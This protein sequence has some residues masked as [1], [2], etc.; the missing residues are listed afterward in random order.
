MATFVCHA[1]ASARP[2]ASGA[3]YVS[4]LRGLGT[5]SKEALANSETR[6]PVRPQRSAKG[7]AKFWTAT[8]LVICFQLIEEFNIGHCGRWPRSHKIG[9]QTDRPNKPPYSEY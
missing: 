8:N 4:G 6:K 7:S 9:Q 5:A 1:A 3:R 2:P